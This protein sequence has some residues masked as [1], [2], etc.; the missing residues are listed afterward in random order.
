MHESDA[1]EAYASWLNDPEVN[2]YLATKHATSAELRKYIEEKNRKP[3][4]ELFGIF[5]R[6]G[7]RHVGTLKLEPIDRAAK[8]ATLGILIGDKREWGKG[9]AGEAIRLAIA[10]CFGELGME[11]VW[12]GVI[13]QNTS[14][15]RAYQKL[16]FVETARKPGSVVFPNGVFDQVEM[17]LRKNYA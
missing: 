1:S 16:G 12:L 3:D 9:Y 5:L 17:I 14:A 10:H 6:E 8:K 4:T 2:R 15:L 11:E 13:A 7:D